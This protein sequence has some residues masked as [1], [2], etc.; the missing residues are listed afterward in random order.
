MISVLYP[1]LSSSSPSWGGPWPPPPHGR[2]QGQEAFTLSWCPRSLHLPSIEGLLPSGC[3]LR[4]HLP[5]RQMVCWSTTIL[6]APDGDSLGRWVCEKLV[7]NIEIVNRL[8]CDS[9][10]PFNQEKLAQIKE[11]LS[12]ESHLHSILQLSLLRNPV[13]CPIAELKTSPLLTS[14][15]PYQTNAGLPVLCH[16]FQDRNLQSSHENK[17]KDLAIPPPCT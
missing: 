4:G 6:R 12:N 8:E 16:F 2:V 14:G 3:C 10:K 9:T 7:F 5:W 15:T 11:A 1:L 13:A 17:I